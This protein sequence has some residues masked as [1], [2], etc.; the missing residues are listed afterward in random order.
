MR[1]EAP[2]GSLP[3]TQVR[4]MFASGGSLYYAVTGG[5]LNRIGF[6][7]GVTGTPGPGITGSPVLV[8]SSRDWTAPGMTLTP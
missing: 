3:A 8:D 6:N 5:A 4:G 1:F 7:P 2:A